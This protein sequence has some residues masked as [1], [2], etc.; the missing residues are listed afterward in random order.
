MALGPTQYSNQETLWVAPPSWDLSVAQ[1]NRAQI[2]PTY[3]GDCLAFFVIFRVSVMQI[4]RKLCRIV[5]L[6]FEL[7][8]FRFAD[9][10]DRKV[11][12]S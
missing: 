1:E 9:V 11:N 8:T 4:A 10:S 7:I 12:I 3:L 6:H 5:L 2:G